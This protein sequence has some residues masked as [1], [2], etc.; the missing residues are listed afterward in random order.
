M[1][2]PL[3][4]FVANVPPVAKRKPYSRYQYWLAEERALTER[5]RAETTKMR[6]DFHAFITAKK[7]WPEYIEFVLES[8]GCPAETIKTAVGAMRNAGEAAAATPALPSSR[9]PLR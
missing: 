3:S 6:E 9:Q 8:D 7:L 5:H 4:D 1:A 2:E